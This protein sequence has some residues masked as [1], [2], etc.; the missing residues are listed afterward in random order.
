[1]SPLLDTRF[2]LAG[3]FDVDL[4]LSAT[5]FRAG[6]RHG[7]TLS[8]Q[9]TLV[10]AVAPFAGWIPASDENEERCGNGHRYGLE[11]PLAL[12]LSVGG[13]YEA[14]IGPRLSLE[15]ARADLKRGGSTI[16]ITAD[17]L[18]AGVLVGF[19]VGFRRLHFLAELT[20]DHEW[21]RLEHGDA[22]RDASGFSLTPSFAFR[23]RF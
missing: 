12:A 16:D 4:L 11:V 19:A 14:W 23:L 22:E 10:T 9:A 13:I 20:A 6:P 17:G 3:G 2:G 8:D 18:R 5:T 1:M 7:V 15:R 21:W